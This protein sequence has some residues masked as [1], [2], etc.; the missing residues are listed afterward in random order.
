MAVIFVA[1]CGPVSARVPLRMNTKFS[2][3]PNTLPPQ[4]LRSVELGRVGVCAGVM[5]IAACRENGLEKKDSSPGI[6]RKT[7]IY[8]MSDGAG[9]T[10][11]KSGY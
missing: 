2:G 4:D 5:T 11:R 6:P 7:G 10:P 3:I 9:Q 8:N 1:D